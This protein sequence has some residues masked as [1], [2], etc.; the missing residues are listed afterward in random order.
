MLMVAMF[1]ER[2]WH[3]PELPETEQLRDACF[4]TCDNFF[5]REEFC[6]PALSES[7]CR[8]FQ[9]AFRSTLRE[10]MRAGHR[11]APPALPHIT[12]LFDR[13]PSGPDAV[14]LL[15]APRCILYEPFAASEDAVLTAGY[16]FQV[17]M[18]LFCDDTPTQ[19]RPDGGV[20]S[21]A[22]AER[23]LADLLAA[24]NISVE[25]ARRYERDEGI[26]TEMERARFRPAYNRHTDDTAA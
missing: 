6:P 17:P 9:D 20:P 1:H 13:T 18:Y 2:K 24:A 4:R 14:G 16:G 7:L 19:Y 26:K 8:D 15:T 5:A 23:A 22:Q 10:I 25:R 3:H 21:P 12:S 11:S